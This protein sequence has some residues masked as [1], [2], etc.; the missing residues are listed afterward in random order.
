MRILSAS[1][2][3]GF[4]FHHSATV[5][6]QEV[7]LGGFTELRSDAAGPDFAQRFIDRFNGLERLPTDPGLPADFLERLKSAEGVP[8]VEL[9]FHAVMAVEGAMVC[10]LRHLNM[11]DFSEVVPGPSP[12]HAAFVW[13]CRVPDVSR[14]TAH[15]ALTGLR[16]LLP[17]ELRWDVD[18]IDGDFDQGFRVLLKFARQWRLSNS[19]SYQ[20]KAVERNGI[21]WQRTVGGYIR[22]GQG[23]FQHVFERTTPANCPVVA[24]HLATD[25]GMANRLLAASGLPVPR[26]AEASS[27]T[28]ALSVAKEIGFPVV[29][30]PVNG[31]RS[32]GVTA[33]LNK[34]DE[35][36]AAYD[37]AREV[38]S[39]VI[40][41][42]FLEG[43]VHRLLVASGRFVAA[44][45]KA[46]PSVTG[47][48]KRTIG[49]LIEALN[50]DP[51][52]DGTKLHQIK[53]DEE[54]DRLLGCAGYTFDTVLAKDEVFKLRS[55][56]SGQT[57]GINMDVTDQVHPDNKDLAVRAARI[58]GLPMAGLDFITTD[59]SRSHKEVGGGINEINASSGLRLS[60]QP[61][62]GEP[63]DIGNSIV[64]AMFPLEEQRDVSTTVLTGRESEP[65]ARILDRILRAVWPGVALVT[66]SDATVDGNQTGL[67]NAGPQETTQAVLCDRRVEA[68]VRTVTPEHV[69]RHGLLHSSCEVAALMDRNADG[70]TSEYLQGLDIVVRA[71]S[72]KLAVAANNKQALDIVRDVDPKR[73]I[74]ISRNAGRGTIRR[75][76]DAGGTAVVTRGADGRREI[77]V[78]SGNSSLF[79]IP[80]EDVGDLGRQPSGTRLKRHLF[81]VALAH[82]MGLSAAQILSALRIDQPDEND[83]AMIHR[84]ND[85]PLEPQNELRP[86]DA[87]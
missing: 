85:P 21:P 2:L 54:L 83:H 55:I 40:V 44:T 12:G 79:S 43:D 70:D 49:K 69:L 75:H 62:E 53:R 57:G 35:I 16:E 76:L 29:V 15:L 66:D 48:G 65:V 8:F 45:K 68:L 77:T 20:I 33:G 42:S 23:S 5:I 14:R 28:A 34:P 78:L 6:S 61:P 37:R 32:K 87:D 25:K 18:E 71:T 38:R 46:V 50:A 41:E 36:P 52:R 27:A 58:M 7:D 74:L 51:R 3:S 80:I 10:I 72:G 31:L 84:G 67:E 81:A 59:I 82:G 30:K 64:E 4:N 63:P 86:K 1:I 19:E 17:D 26:Q 11:I 39:R 9:L 60:V 56:P 22:L 73:L 47:D 24:S 13:R